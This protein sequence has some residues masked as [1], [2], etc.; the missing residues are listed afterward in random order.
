M[1]DLPPFV[2]IIVSTVPDYKNQFQCCSILERNVGTDNMIEVQTISEHQTVL[3]D[4]LRRHGR[5]LTEQ[6]SE[7][8]ARYFDYDDQSA[9]VKRSG[10]FSSTA[11][12]GCTP[13]WLAIVAQT[14]ASW[15]SYD[16]L[17]SFERDV[18][19]DV[20]GLI[21]ALFD[22]LAKDHGEYL[23]KATLSYITLA[24]VGISETELNHV[25]S[26]EDDVIADVYEWWVPPVRILPPL[27]ITRVLT[28]LH[29]YLT[30]RGDGSGVHLVGW[31]HRQFWEGAEAWL[32]P[33]GKID[34]T[35]RHRHGELAD[36]FQGKWSDISKPYNDFLRGRVQRPQF[37]PGEESANRMVPAQPRVLHGNFWSSRG[38]S[39][40]QDIQLNSRR[41]A[42]LVHHLIYAGE[43]SR[44]VEELQTPEYIASKFFIKD[45]A[46]LLQEFNL[47]TQLFPLSSKQLRLSKAS[48]GVGVMQLQRLPPPYILQLASQEPDHHPLYVAGKLSE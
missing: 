38:L 45:G 26:C 6:Q 33:F 14:A 15:P 30:F 9:L 42:E 31:Y 5:K 7:A 32:F 2:R 20:R 22:R 23:I 48:V 29:Q 8:I 41:L 17:K 34:S 25:C 24:K 16:E 37:F 3:A 39:A 19:P 47:A 4:M 12:V 21:V 36:Y 43:E 28:D 18:K 1:R 40:D 35:K 13:L 27:L 10:S 44:A 46:G 11:Q